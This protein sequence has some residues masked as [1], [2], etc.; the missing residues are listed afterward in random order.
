MPMSKEP[1][2]FA[3]AGSTSSTARP[4]RFHAVATAT[5]FVVGV[6]A[7]CVSDRT[8]L[9]AQ[10]TSSSTSA[11]NA[12]TSIRLSRPSFEQATSQKLPSLQIIPRRKIATETQTLAEVELDANTSTASPAAEPPRRSSLF[13]SQAAEVAGERSNPISNSESDNPP[14]T[15]SVAATSSD[16]ARPRWSHPP[17][18]R[19]T[20]PA[21]IGRQLQSSG[22][23][24][25]VPPPEH[26]TTPAEF[27]AQFQAMRNR[28][29]VLPGAPGGP[30]AAVETPHATTQHSTSQYG[31]PAVPTYNATPSFSKAQPAPNAIDG[32][33]SETPT[34]ANLYQQQ[35]TP[36][37]A[38]KP[39]VP[40]QPFGIGTPRFSAD[41]FASADPG[42]PAAGTNNFVRDDAAPPASDYPADLIPAQPQPRTILQPQPI[43]SSNSGQVTP[44][45]ELMLPKPGDPVYAPQVIQQPPTHGQPS[46]AIAEPLIAPDANE[47][48]I[49]SGATGGHSM[50]SRRPG[51]SGFRA[52]VERDA[53]AW[54]QPYSLRATQQSGT[55][56]FTLPGEPLSS[57]PGEFRPWWD[58]IVRQSAGI[59][60]SSIPVDVGRLLQ[61]ALLFSPQVTAI[62]AE[63]EV[64]YRVITQEAARFD[65]SVFL[66]ATYDDLNDPIGNALVTDNGADR[67]IV[68]KVVGTGGVRQKNLMGGEL[69]LSQ[70]MGHENQNSSF[71][72]PNN[73]A[74]TRLALSY[75][76]PLL[77]GAGR[78][79]NE[80]EVVLARIRANSSEDE[81]VDALQD[82][83]IEV[84]KAYWTLYRARA[85][86]F[87]RRKLLESSRRIL[88]RLEGRTQVDTIPRQVLRARAA[89]ARA[90][91][92]IQRT[93]SRVKDAEAQ[94]RLLV[95]SPQMLN[96]GPVELTPVEPPRM[97]TESA[98]LRSV[99]QTAL[100]NRPDISE[101]IRRMRAS[102]V[103]LGVS[104]SE[105]LP[106][107]DFLVET[108]VADLAGSSNLRRAL[109][110]QYFDNR[111]GYTVGLEF[112]Y[113]I[114]NRAARAK[115]EQR[116]WELKRSINV[117][118]AT[119]EKSLTDVEIANR[120]VATAYSEMLS[121]YQSMKAAE[122]EANYLQDRF[123]VLPA[124]EDSAVLLLEDLLDSFE[125]VADEESSFVQAQVD[126]AV[127]LI[128]LKK[129]LGILLQSRH[130][131][132][133]V[134]PTQQ[135]W[136]EHRIN[137]AF[138]VPDRTIN[139]THRLVGH[140][141]S[142]AAATTV[143]A[144]DEASDLTAG[145]SRPIP[146]TPTTW[147]RPV[148][149]ANR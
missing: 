104:K 143:N 100:M 129:E 87:Q 60:P 14:A 142:N 86:Y 11:N 9:S 18:K 68:R 94:L 149:P 88:N 93:I 115:L 84:T 27:E 106:R 80:S 6:L 55:D 41:P 36:T 111:P 95:N 113:P 23:R 74:A 69:Q 75:R 128:M 89:V 83:L 102:S 5:V 144:D 17:V 20:V 120:E 140:S 8:D 22:S 136:I 138:D 47:H 137:S 117:F 56:V 38:G 7:F 85:E 133:A 32:L 145:H 110:G 107:L 64:Q 135:Q 58:P 121:R 39:L 28:W 126:H 71:F 35:T 10:Q 70:R 119:V 43:D 105:L 57:I 59:A 99:L 103:R 65:W 21:E 67:L 132:P 50:F 16:P 147:T 4:R 92:R 3:H 114:E 127:A 2:E 30:D 46:A 26:D 82:H 124:S 123:D 37:P 15:S 116:Q 112:E 19:E 101:A 51:T 63:P 78:A 109:N 96:G 33:S 61:D 91:T 134:E 54:M 66:D 44:G 49:V 48:A 62:K 125:R 12:G 73:Q 141:P 77:D 42:A 79:Y 139:E 118:R 148:S 131:R 98:D 122:D 52:T 40:G 1:E 130:A 29:S 13:I 76:Q 31:P 34:A 97:I 108:Y 45:R 25:S 53:A 146:A 24:W 90:Q 72:V 81:V